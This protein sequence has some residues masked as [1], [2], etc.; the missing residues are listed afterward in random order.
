MQHFFLRYV[1]YDKRE[2]SAPIELSVSCYA[3]LDSMLTPVILNNVH[4]NKLTMTLNYMLNLVIIM[5]IFVL[6]I[7]LRFSVRAENLL[8]T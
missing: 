6:T 8:T 5:S 3:W 7:K 4:R 1:D 2:F